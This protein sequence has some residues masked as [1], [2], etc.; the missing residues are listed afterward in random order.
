MPECG[1][2]GRLKQTLRKPP[3]K[4]DDAVKLKPSKKP[5]KINFLRK[6]SDLKDRKAQVP[7]NNNTRAN[8][9][10]IYLPCQR[11]N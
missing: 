7:S 8:G 5:D 2:S 10:K 9:T 1:R 4:Q 6:S 11:G 3:D